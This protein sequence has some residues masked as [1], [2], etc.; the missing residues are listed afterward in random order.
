MSMDPHDDGTGSVTGLY[1][2]WQSGDRSG[3]EQLITH[4]RSRLLALANSVRDRRFQ[5]T[6]EA[7]DAL[8]SAMFSLWESPN[9]GGLSESAD[10][11]DLWNVLGTMT[12]RK[13][14]RHSERERAQKRGGGKVITGLPVEAI[15]IVEDGALGAHVDELLELLDEDLRRFAVL[16]LSGHTNQEIAGELDCSERKVE[17]KLQLVRAVWQEEM[18]RWTA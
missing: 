18:D 5:S 13:V 2:R 17:R 1:Q 8:Q 3:F 14:L 11:D 4:F 15:A 16:R 7:E 9:Q 12:V 6:A 10:R